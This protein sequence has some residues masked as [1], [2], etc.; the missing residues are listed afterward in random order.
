MKFTTEIPTKYLST[1]EPYIEMHFVIA[2]YLEKDPDYAFFFQKK[3]KRPIILDNGMFEMGYP[4]Q[5]EHLVEWAEKLHPELVF[6][7]DQHPNREETL[8]LSY[9]FIKLCEG[10]NVPKETIGLI[11]QGK[12]PEEVCECWKEMQSWGDYPIGLSFLND[13]PKVIELGLE[14][15]LFEPK[16][17]YHM[18]GLYNLMDIFT[19]PAQYIK[20]MDTIKPFKA[21]L[22]NE[23]ILKGTRGGGKWNTTMQLQNKLQMELLM[24]N[25]QILK[26]TLK[27]CSYISKLESL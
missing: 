25:I 17:W 13:R 12:D 9:A 18:L 27:Q 1:L 26:T 10:R 7:P 3:V 23:S 14:Q 16:R 11:P 15:K 19:W 4:M 2:T 21:A 6:A 22:R 5:P 8:R 20:S 24:T